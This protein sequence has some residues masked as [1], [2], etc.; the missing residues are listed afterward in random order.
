MAFKATLSTDSA[1]AVSRSAA[2][3]ILTRPSNDIGDS[4]KAAERRAI[5]HRVS[6]EMVTAIQEPEETYHSIHAAARK[7]MPCDSFVI[8]L[9]DEH[10]KENVVVYAL[11][12]DTRYPVQHIPAGRGLSGTSG[13]D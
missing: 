9:F 7:L 11:E 1:S 3:R 8:S 10:Q 13:S 5:L 2:W 12:G 4:P 6:Q